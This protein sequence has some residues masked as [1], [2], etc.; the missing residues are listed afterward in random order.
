M[1]YHNSELDLAQT[2]TPNKC[3]AFLVSTNRLKGVFY[4]LR[5]RGMMG[6]KSLRILIADDDPEL[7]FCLCGQ[8]HNLGHEVVAAATDGQ[9]AI[10]LARWHRPEL[11]MM[12]IKMPNLDGLE[13]SRQIAQDMPCPIILLSAY[14]NP[15]LVREASLLPVQAYLVKPVLEHEL[16]PAIETA[17]MRFQ[18][19]QQLRNELTRIKQILDTRR[20]IQ[21]ATTYLIENRDCTPEE[22]L[23]RIQQEARAKRVKLDEVARAIILDQPIS[24]RYAVPI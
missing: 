7:R 20:T 11:I 22:A 3:R 2:T 6:Y 24:Y 12:D 9:E 4:L 18:E 23:D 8:L 13:A 16:E 15:D 5:G 1:W 14:S 10:C 19:N 21:E 17:M